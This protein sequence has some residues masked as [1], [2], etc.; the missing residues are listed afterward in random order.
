MYVWFVCVC[1]CMLW[2][3]IGFIHIFN[4]TCC[5]VWGLV[6]FSI[7]F[8]LLSC[9]NINKN[10]VRICRWTIFRWICEPLC[11]IKCKIIMIIMSLQIGSAFCYM[12]ESPQKNEFN[13][14]WYSHRKLPFHW[15]ISSTNHWFY[16]NAQSNAIFH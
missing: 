12:L 13:L 5:W 10:D 16:Y 7:V 14:W 9:I 4:Q 11:K 8:V 3:S 1:V 2:E 6:D 15:I